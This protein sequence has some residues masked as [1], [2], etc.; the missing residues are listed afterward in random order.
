MSQSSYCSLLNGLSWVFTG[1]SLGECTPENRGAI[2]GWCSSLNALSR[3]LGPPLAGGFFRLGCYL[4]NDT[5]EL[6]RYLSFYVNMI[7]GAVFCQHGTRQVMP[8]SDFLFFFEPNLH[9][10]FLSKGW[11]YVSMQLARRRTNPQVP[12]QRKVSACL[13]LAQP[14]DAPLEESAELRVA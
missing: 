13:V 4:E 3:G 2:N 14:E 6:G 10:P 5:F 12:P 11:Q 9:K 1:F 7:T 8:F